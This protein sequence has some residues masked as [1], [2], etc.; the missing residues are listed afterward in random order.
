LQATRTAKAS[1]PWSTAWL[2]TGLC[3]FTLLGG[4]IFILTAMRPQRVARPASFSTFAAKDGSFRCEY[5]SG[6]KVRSAEAGAVTSVALFRKSEAVIEVEASLAD[7][8]MGD[9]MRV[10]GAPDGGGGE[11]PGGGGGTPDFSGVGIQDFDAMLQDLQRPPVERLHAMK[12]RDRA[13]VFAK[14]K[15]SPM[16]VLQSAY[17]DGRFSEFTH[18]GDFF[19]QKIHGYRATLL[20]GERGV[21]VICQC[22]EADW[23]NLMQA[24][25]RVLGSI[26][27]GTQQ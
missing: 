17:G 20:G 7:S 14:Y 27:A 15:E 16:Q 1:N 2:L 18:K 23:P 24:Y 26:A 6:W 11:A 5:P 9:I 25:Q 19:T 4:V 12:G 3:I 13:K 21:T 8:L 10:P 22:P